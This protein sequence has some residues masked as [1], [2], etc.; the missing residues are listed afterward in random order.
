MKLSGKESFSNISVVTVAVAG[1][2]SVASVIVMSVISLSGLMLR[3]ESLA[4]S[5]AIPSP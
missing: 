5:F 4:Y 1:L 2:S 3:K